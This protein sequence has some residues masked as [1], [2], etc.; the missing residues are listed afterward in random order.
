ML[1]LLK[2]SVFTL[3]LAPALIS[4]QGCGGCGFQCE[5]Q[6]DDPAP[7]SLNISGSPSNDIKSIV[8]EIEKITFSRTDA[9]DVEIDTFTIDALNLKDAESFQVDLLEFAGLSSLLVIDERE[10]ENANYNS[11]VLTINDNDINASYVE[12]AQDERKELN[13]T[14][15]TLTLSGVS[16]NNKKQ[17]FTI[18][19]SAHQSLVYVPTSDDYQL[20]TKGTRVV[21]NAKAGSI[22]G[23][24]STDLFDQVAPCDAK[25]D[26]EQ[27]NR[28][29]L[30]QGK[31]LNS[32]NLVD[33]YTNNTTT[34]AP[35]DA[36]S[37]FESDIVYNVPRSNRWEYSLGYLPAGD[38]TLVYTCAAQTD[39]TKDYDNISMPLPTAQI[40]EITLSEGEATVCD[41]QDGASCQ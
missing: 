38:Y 37:P 5:D 11:I 18:K 41:L 40:Y 6:E 28:L 23:N 21:D 30:Y 8:L 10:F 19:F 1:S 15:T 34:P 26:P 13:V 36:I 25:A 24:V 3:V 31:S 32:D 39:D 29:Y 4:L 7:L 12:N 17:E 2:F 16:V 14:G 33:F 9:D 27:G 22:A 35:A 20:T